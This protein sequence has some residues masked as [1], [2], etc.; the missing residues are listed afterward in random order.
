MNEEQAELMRQAMEQQQ[1]QSAGPFAIV[2]S[3]IYLA[4]IAVAIAGMW[5]MFVKAGQPGW[6]AIV[7]IYNLYILLTIVGRPIWW[8]ALFLLC[9]PAGLIAGIIVSIDLA[10]SFGKGTGF[11][12]GIALLGFIFIPML[13]FGDAQYQGPAAAGGGGIATA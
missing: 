7:P 9:P 13:G 12:I 6:A 1:A 10:R 5:K 3:I 11:G 2:M 8:L 4:V